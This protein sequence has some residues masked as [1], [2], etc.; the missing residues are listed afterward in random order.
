MWIFLGQGWNP[1]ILHW[2]V[3][4]YTT[5]PSGK[6]LSFHFKA[7][8]FPV[9]LAGTTGDL[10]PEKKDALLSQEAVVQPWPIL[11]SEKQGSLTQDETGKGGCPRRAFKLLSVVLSTP[12]EYFLF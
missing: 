8:N 7:R 9:R 1:C 5:E 10:A 12:F 6:P 4:F 3:D 11:P 2:Q